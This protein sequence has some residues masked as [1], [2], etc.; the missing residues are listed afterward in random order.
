[1]VENDVGGGSS[2]DKIYHL[3][4]Y[5]TILSTHGFTQTKGCSCGGVRQEKYIRHPYTVYVKIKA[6]T[7][8]IKQNNTYITPSRPIN[9]LNEA[10]VTQVVGV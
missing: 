8:R 7:F 1:M 2:S 3:T 4:D 10:L 6:Q 9:T 5:Q